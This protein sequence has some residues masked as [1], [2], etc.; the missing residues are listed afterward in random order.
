[1]NDEPAKEERTKMGLGP[2]FIWISPPIHKGHRRRQ[3]R[4]GGREEEE[5]EDPRQFVSE[6]EVKALPSPSNFPHLFL[7]HATFLPPVSPSGLQ[8]MVKVIW[9]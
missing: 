9:R 7:L 2:S 8:M 1:M 5:K 6:N 4:E 3:R